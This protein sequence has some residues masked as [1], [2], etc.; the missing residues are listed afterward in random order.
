[1]TPRTPD[2]W[3]CRTVELAARVL[4]AEHRH[5]YAREFIGELHGMPRSQQV[6]HS[7]QVLSRAWTLLVALADVARVAI[8]ENAVKHPFRWWLL[9]H[10]GRHLWVQYRNPEV[11]GKDAVFEPGHAY[12]RS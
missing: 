8:E 5:R 10:L 1:V 4:P 9:C 6:R 3:C 12:C 2:R 7:V 11:G